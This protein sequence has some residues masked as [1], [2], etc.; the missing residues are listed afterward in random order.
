MANLY[1]TKIIVLYSVILCQLKLLTLC[2]AI[3]RQPRRIP[4]HTA[5][6]ECMLSLVFWPYLTT[7]ILICNEL[8]LSHKYATSSSQQSLFH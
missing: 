3:L 1:P 4:T 2:E 5:Q 6:Q 7:F 8:P